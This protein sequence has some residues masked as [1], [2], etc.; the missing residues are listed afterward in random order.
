MYPLRRARLVLIALVL[1]IVAL[2]TSAGGLP[3]PLLLL[4]PEKAAA[5]PGSSTTFV[6]QRNKFFDPPIVVVHE[7]DSVAWVMETNGGWHDVQ[8]YEGLFSSTPMEYG[9]VFIQTFDQ[10]GTY[11]YYCTPHVVDGMK[12]AV[13]VLPQGVPLPNPLPVPPAPV[14]SPNSGVLVD[15]GAPDT[16]VTVAGGGGNGGRATEASLYLP[17]GVAVDDLGRVYISDTENCQ[18]RRVDASGTVVSVFGHESCGVSIWGEADL[19]PWLHTNHPRGASI[20]PDG[21]LYVADIVNCRVRRVKQNGTVDTYVGVGTCRATGD[22]GLAVEAGV[23]PWGLAWDS[24][25][26]LYVADVFN[27]RIRKI[28]QAGIITTVAGNGTCGFSGDGGPAT[29]ASLFFP[30]DVAVGPDQGLYLADSVNCRV[31]RVDLATGAIDT[32]A[33]GGTCSYGGDGGPATGAGIQPW[34]IDVHP[35]GRVLVADRE[36]CR[37]RSFVP[38]GEIA[39]VAGTGVCGYSGDGGSAAQAALNWPSAVAIADDGQAYVADTG[40]CRVR[41]IDGAGTIQTMA[42]SGVCKHG[43]DGG[44]AV[45]GGNWHPIGLA[46]GEQGDLYFSELDTCLIRHIDTDG[47]IDSV[48]GTGICGFSTDARPAKESRLSDFLG[49]VALGDD[50]SVFFAEGYNC[51]VRRIDPDGTIETVAGTGF[52]RFSGDGGPADEADLNVVTDVAMDGDGGLLLAGPSDCR[53][54][55]VDLATGII[56]TI[57]GDG[58]CLYNGEDVPA[59]EAGV[60][61]WG[62]AVGPDGAVYMADAGNC[63]VRRLGTDGRVTTVAGSGTCGYDG[64]GGP[65]TEGQLIQPYDLVLDA[66]GNLYVVDLRAFTVRKVDTEGTISTVAGIGI[67]RPLDIGGYDPTDG[68]FCTVNNLP[69]P[70]PSYLGDGGPADQAGLYVPYGVALDYEGHLYIADTFTHRI[71]RVTCGGNVPCVGPVR[72]GQPPEDPTPTEVTPTEVPPTD[73]APTDVTPTRPT[74]TDTASPDSTPTP[75]GGPSDQAAGSLFPPDTGSHARS[76]KPAPLVVPLAAVGGSLL[77]GG[78]LWLLG[79]G[80]RRARSARP[81]L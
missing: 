80:Q 48:A 54:R 60:E 70:I 10:A 18:V 39:T 35:D 15:P 25:R 4:S 55:R 79:E 46:I 23:A 20:G 47:V 64:D 49:G 31:R 8:S 72:F 62:V 38:G 67:S 41:R 5:D 75:D 26:N 11:G 21:A 52:C 36:N 81:K 71:R 66:D 7:G 68:L 16:I 22:G 33:G 19:G 76:P 69:V 6:R 9:D 24:Q 50:G 43:G 44:P 2:A 28:D 53:I 42:G 27:C 56:D 58:S 32:V 57:A 74:P 13:V 34:G 51:R 40:N 45:A 30:R 12:G 14:S 17:E 61:P 37:V 65:A 73:P 59:E 1:G 78:A 77:L 63:R 29:Q 3:L